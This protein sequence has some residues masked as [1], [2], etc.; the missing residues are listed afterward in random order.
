MFK[1]RKR[2]LSLMLVSVLMISLFAGCGVIR[3]KPTP[4]GLIGFASETLK[5]IESEDITLGIYVDLS[6]ED[7]EYSPVNATVEI[8]AKLHHKSE[9]SHMIV[10]GD[11]YIDGKRS[12]H[13]IETYLVEEDD[14]V[15]YKKDTVDGKSSGWIL[16]DGKKSLDIETPTM[17]LLELLEAED[18]VPSM[19]EELMRYNDNMCYVVDCCLDDVSEIL[20][21]Y[22]VEDLT[23]IDYDEVKANIQLYFDVETKHLIGMQI[24]FKDGINALLKE[25]GD[26]ANAEKMLITV[27]YNS[28]NEL[29]TIKVPKSVKKE[30][31]EAK[32]EPPT[33][34][35]PVAQDK[36]EATEPEMSDRESPV[37]GRA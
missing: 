1:N 20:D 24:D 5:G 18:V 22:E 8:Q 17:L 26:S 6:S 10:S 36:A 14:W 34:T 16:K 28:I 4:D 7:D 9:T 37:N 15:T 29:R 32:T 13:E 21:L 23:G 31:E 3:P 27:T 11:M 19:H 2:T 25:N 33:E 30:I 12:K 35:M